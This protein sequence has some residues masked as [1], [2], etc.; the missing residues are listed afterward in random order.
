MPVS[1]AQSGAGIVL[2]QP[3]STAEVSTVRPAGSRTH[4]CSTRP[5][6]NHS[7]VASTAS[8][9]RTSCL[10]SEVLVAT[11]TACAGGL[12]AQGTEGPGSL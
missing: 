7:L 1:A 6:A 5:S 11:I 4:R 3:Y 12:D 10:R 8:S 9:S 2:S